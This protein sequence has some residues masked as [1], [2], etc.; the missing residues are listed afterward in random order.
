MA[1][2]EKVYFLKSP[3][4]EA[5]KKKLQRNIFMLTLRKEDSSKEV[6]NDFYNK[7]ILD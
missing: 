3:E 6:Q 1:K 7:W 4:I 5:N 2:R